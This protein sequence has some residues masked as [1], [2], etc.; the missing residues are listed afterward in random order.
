MFKIEG[1]AQRVL[2][3]VLVLIQGLGL[4]VYEEGT[5]RLV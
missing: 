5:V 4:C 2:T 3:Y 1:L